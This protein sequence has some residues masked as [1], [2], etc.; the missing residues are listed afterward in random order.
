MFVALSTIPS[1]RQILCSV[2]AVDSLQSVCSRIKT[3]NHEVEC[4]S[5]TLNCCC[6][7]LIC[8]CASRARFVTHFR[9]FFCFAYFAY[10]FM[11][12]YVLLFIKS[13]LAGYTNAI[14]CLLTAL[15]QQFFIRAVHLF[16]VVLT[17][18]IAILG[19]RSRIEAMWMVFESNRNSISQTKLFR[20]LLYA[21]SSLEILN[22]IL[23]EFPKLLSTI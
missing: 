21:N 18:P 14:S 2:F 19:V 9:L 12:S 16:A 3:T 17:R 23:S 1:I 11:D 15:S 6:L 4:F 22:N 20:L 10:V 13:I 8:F 7:W 5:A